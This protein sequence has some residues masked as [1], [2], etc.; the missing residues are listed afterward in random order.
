[1]DEL[2]GVRPLLLN[3]EVQRHIDIAVLNRNPV[4]Q[5]KVVAGRLL[6]C[7]NQGA[8]LKSKPL[9]YTITELVLA[10][11]TQALSNQQITF[12]RKVYLVMGYTFSTIYMEGL[13]W[14]DS[15]YT[16]NYGEYDIA[17]MFYIPF[18]GTDLYT[19][20]LGGALWGGEIAYYGFY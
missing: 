1:M 8:V 7:T 17:E 13:Q 14:T 19:I 10:S 15:T 9:G 3:D 18:Q 16:H 20:G 12:P 6:R 5:G 4:N 11:Y 2:N